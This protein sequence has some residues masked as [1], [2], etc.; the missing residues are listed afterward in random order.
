MR[1][2]LLQQG[3]LIVLWRLTQ[4]PCH[5]RHVPVSLQAA[6]VEGVESLSQAK[7]GSALQVIF[8]LDQLKQVGCW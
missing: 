5:H 4:T 3:Y 1:R 6:L 2:C 7:V 8:N